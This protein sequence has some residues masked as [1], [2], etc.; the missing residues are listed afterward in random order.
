MNVAVTSGSYEA[1]VG[2]RPNQAGN[3]FPGKSGDGIVGTGDVTQIRRFVL[4]F[5]TPDTGERPTN[6]KKQTL[7]LSLLLVTA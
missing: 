3:P 2:P 7:L 4:G 1:D 6:F 5:D